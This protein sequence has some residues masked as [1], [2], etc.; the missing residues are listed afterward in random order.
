MNDSSPCVTQKRHSSRT[1]RACT[2]QFLCSSR[3]EEWLWA[4]PNRLAGRHSY[5]PWGSPSSQTV[6]EDTA[7]TVSH[8][9]SIQPTRKQKSGR[10]VFTG[11]WNRFMY[12]LNGLLSE[13]TFWKH[14]R[15]HV[16]FDSMIKTQVCGHDDEHYEQDV[17]EGWTHSR[18]CTVSSIK[19]L[20]PLEPFII[21][22]CLFTFI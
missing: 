16:S 3:R 14:G 2:V 9:M 1:S 15:E 13:V 7:S 8:S 11:L 19:A 17:A 10:G 20:C 12:N 22:T 21:H 6:T 18:C 4:W 5:K